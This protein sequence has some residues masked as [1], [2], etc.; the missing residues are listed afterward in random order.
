MNKTAWFVTH[1]DYIDRR[2]FFFVDVLREHGYTVKLFPYFYFNALSAQDGSFVKRPIEEK[3]VVEYNVPKSQAADEDVRLFDAIIET[4]NKYYRRYGKWTAKNVKGNEAK[5]D[6]FEQFYRITIR[7]EGYTICYNSLTET[8]S[9]IMDTPYAIELRKCHQAILDSV[10]NDKLLACDEVIPCDDVE[11]IKTGKEENG[12]F[13]YAHVSQTNVMYKYSAD[14]ETMQEITIM[15]NEY[16]IDRMGGVKYDF[17]DFRDVIYDYSPIFQRV[18]KELETETPDIVYVADLPTLPIGIMLKKAVNCRLIMDCHE[19]WYKQTVLWEANNSRKIDLVDKYEKE[20]YPQCDLC[21]TVGENLAERMKEY[22]GCA[23]E[24]VY[25]CMSQT[26]SRHSDIDRNFI[27][28]K[29]HLAPESRIAI[30]QGGMS[31]FRNLEN[32]ARATKYLENDSYLLLLTTGAYQ[33][34]FKE[35]LKKEGNADRVIWGGWIKQQELLNYTQNVDVGVIPYTAVNDYSECFVPN[36]LMEYFEVQLP[37]FYD[38]SM[39]EL[40]LVAGGNGVGCGADLKNAEEFGRKLN[41]LLHDREKLE[42]YKQNYEKCHDKFG[43]ISQ[44]RN[45]DKMLTTYGLHS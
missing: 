28:E 3:L 23:F 25:S 33:K 44:K 30:F 20:L 24:V 9:R 37:I 41:E 31:T 8:I 7:R 26:L 36:K 4:E 14:A 13:I 18:M 17:Q 2:I 5:I 15:P 42:E 22:M 21:I 10:L 27:L 39:R 35:I 45:F 16:E 43:Y 11:V 29:Y 40:K 19:W 6:V 34:K 1:D 38:V 32:L 12:T